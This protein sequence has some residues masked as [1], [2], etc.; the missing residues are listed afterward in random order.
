MEVEGILFLLALS[1]LFAEAAYPIGMQFNG[2]G[3]TPPY[4]CSMDDW[5]R[6]QRDYT[7]SL[8]LKGP[9]CPSDS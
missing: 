2:N 8:S 1:L 6:E 5:I 4:V 7:D 3:C 9:F